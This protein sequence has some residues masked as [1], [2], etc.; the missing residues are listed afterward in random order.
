MGAHR[1]PQI[2]MPSIKNIILAWHYTFIENASHGQY[3]VRNTG[4]TPGEDA[5]F[6]C[7]GSGKS[8]SS[9]V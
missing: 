2:R 1:L 9:Y 6:S 7:V 5:L 8:D 4:K 3:E